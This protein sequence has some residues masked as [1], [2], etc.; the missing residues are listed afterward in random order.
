[1]G[2]RILRLGTRA[3]R[4]ARWQAEWVG[5]RLGAAGHQ[6]RL[7]EIR[8]T[9]DNRPDV[10]LS[11]LGDGDL[12][13]RQIDQ[14]LLEGA[15]DLAVH[16]LKDLPTRLPEGIELAAVS[17]RE[18]PRD[19]L[20]ARRPV[21]WQDLPAGAV[22][23]TC[24]LRRR[25]QLL[26]VRPDLSLVDIRGNIDGR[27][28]KL[29]QHQDWHATVLAGAGLVRLGLTSRISRRLEFDVMLPAPGQ[30]ALGLT[31]LTGSP[32]ATLARQAVHDAMTGACTTAERAFLHQL[33]SGCHAPV[34]AVATVEGSGLRLRGRVLSLDGQQW[35]QDESSVGQ[36]RSDDSAEHCGRGLALDLL[37][38][39]AERLLAAGMADRR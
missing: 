30:G 19:A 10:P 33:G 24:S 13:T 11:Q 12:F 6:C 7:V 15:I 1:M 32:A 3:S 20:V 16:S 26:R 29:D 5:Q 17:S 4:L 25:A 35:L 23:A 38:R 8:T 28:R 31:A 34:A 18:D 36:L 2:D 22:V 27:L 14:A 21:S 9:G 37:A 39:G